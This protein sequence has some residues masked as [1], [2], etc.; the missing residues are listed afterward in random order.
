MRNS[1]ASAGKLQ[2][3]LDLILLRATEDEDYVSSQKT[4]ELAEFN[5][6]ETLTLNKIARE[7]T[8]SRIRTAEVMKRKLEAAEKMEQMRGENAEALSKIEH[9]VSWIILLFVVFFFDL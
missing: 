4:N 3:E 6:S 2:S 5:H 9:E 1:V 8:A 7:D